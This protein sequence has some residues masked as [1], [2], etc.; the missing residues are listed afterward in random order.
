MTDGWHEERPPAP[1]PLPRRS[2]RGWWIAGGVA[3]CW[4]IAEIM[5]SS[6]IA[7]TVLVVAIGGLGVVSVV[8]LRGAGGIRD[9]PWLRRLIS[10]AWHDGD[11]AL[12]DDDRYEPV[13]PYEPQSQYE[14]HDQ[15]ASDVKQAPD[16]QYTLVAREYPGGNGWYGKQADGVVTMMEQVRPAIP[17]LRLVT[18]SSVAETVMSGAR[19]GRGSVELVLPEVPTVSR[20][21]AK[22]IFSNGRWRVTNQGRNGLFLNGSPVTGEQPVSDGDVIRWGAR[23]DALMSRVEIG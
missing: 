22:F 1:A 9:H 6:A 21:H 10:Q 4:V 13:A 17:V 3:L 18:G 15:Y 20:E 12:D 14:P 7:A 2:R 16:M 23:P 5:T 11:D 8:G 19:A